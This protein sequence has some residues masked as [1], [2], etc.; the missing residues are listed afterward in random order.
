MYNSVAF[1]LQGE[2]VNR[3]MSWVPS[4]YRAMHIRIFRPIRCCVGRNCAGDVLISSTLYIIWQHENYACLSPQQGLVTLLCIVPKVP[5]PPH[6]LRV[7][8]GPPSSAHAQ[9]YIGISSLSPGPF[10]LYLCIISAQ[11]RLALCGRHR[12]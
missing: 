9:L 7:D 11:T 6:R 2:C 5:G 12:D 3:E 1:A 10:S 8:H 4:Q